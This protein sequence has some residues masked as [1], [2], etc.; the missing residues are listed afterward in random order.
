MPLLQYFGWV[1]G[2]LF[3]ALLATNWCFSVAIALAPRS[4]VPFNQRIIV[5]I[6]ADR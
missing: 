4:D 3:A 2:A 6:H 1:G 5:R